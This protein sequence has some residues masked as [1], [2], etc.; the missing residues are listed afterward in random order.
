MNPK[1]PSAGA[2]PSIDASS[3][4]GW[5]PFRHLTQAQF[6]HAAADAAIAVALANTLFFAVPVGEARD[7]VALYLAMTMAPFALLSPLV[8]PLLDRARGGY[9]VAII[10]AGIGRMSLAVLLSSRTD[11]LTLYPLAF[12]LLVLSRIH[13]V[14]RSA[15]V[16]DA[17]PP[18]RSLIWGNSRLAVVSVVGAAVGA[19]LAAAA[20]AGVGVDL[21]LWL[22]AVGF[23]AIGVVGVR[24]PRPDHRTEPPDRVTDYR[25]L[26]SAR[27]VAGGISMAA[28]R[29]AV[30]FLTFLI[31][32][33]LRASG[34]DAAAL[35]VVVAAAGMGGFVGS[36][37]APALRALMP[38][39]WLLLGPLGVM[40]ATSWWAAG[41]FDVEAAAIV[42][43]VVGFG[44]GAGRLAFDSL[45]QHD[46]PEAI[47][48]RT[49]A[50]YETI[51]QLCWVAG[52]G[53]ATLIPFDPTGGLRTLAG[54]C[55]AGAALSA[56]GLLRRTEVSSVSEPPPTRRHPHEA[57]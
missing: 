36:V 6:A 57:P 9:R 50:R 17:L 52:A 23:A 46:A 27:L 41:S 13:G 16:P 7:K 49:F 11:R 43:G 5:P 44:A 12:G 25:Q 37:L 54:I 30:G 32:F 22:A 20:N 8:G 19:G 39:S 35:A 55:V 4:T 15:L 47:R 48:G 26:L 18:H 38:E 1:P 34:E 28:S 24:L 53:V 14:S 40:A 45:L 3:V 29:A 56:R 33:L 51:F 31:A 42:A 21:S 10:G 2:E